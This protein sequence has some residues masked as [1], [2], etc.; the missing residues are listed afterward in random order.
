MNAADQHIVISILDQLLFLYAENTIVKRYPIATA[1]NG[2][3]Q[4]EGSECTPLGRHQ[5]VEKIGVDAAENAVFIGRQW[6]GEL[7]TE[8]LAYENPERDWILTRILWL[9]GL[10]NGFN[11][12][13]LEHKKALKQITKQPH[14]PAISC[15]TK[16]RY[17]YIHGCPDSHAMQ[18]P[19]SHGCIKMRNNDIIEL[20]DSVTVNTK[21]LIQLT[22]SN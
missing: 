14:K 21:V 8:N 3:S 13:Y 1:K 6:N 4:Q 15:D 9:G 2:I 18:I 7:Y 20:F 5:I 17:I 12:G 11:S 19:S 22:H 16:K 10:E